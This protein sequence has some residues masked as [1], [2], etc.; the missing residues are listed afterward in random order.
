MQLPDRLIKITGKQQE[1]AEVTQLLS[2]HRD[3]L[4][5]LAHALVT[6]FKSQHGDPLLWASCGRP[7]HH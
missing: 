5:S 4:D 7:A 3:Q 2:E 1:H 6:T